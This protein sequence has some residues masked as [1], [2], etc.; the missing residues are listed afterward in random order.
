MTNSDLMFWEA[1]RI[2]LC[3]ECYAA[4]S[5]SDSESEIHESELLQAM[6]Q[7]HREPGFLAFLMEQF[8]QDERS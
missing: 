3:T 8:D 6:G 1:D 5:E 2:W 4:I 7:V